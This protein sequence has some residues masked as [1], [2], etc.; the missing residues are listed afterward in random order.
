MSVSRNTIRGA[1]KT[2]Y[3]SRRIHRR[4]V[5]GCV[6]RGSAR[7]MRRLWKMQETMKAQGWSV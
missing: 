2:R 1:S 3:L 6:K 7:R 4:G 5:E